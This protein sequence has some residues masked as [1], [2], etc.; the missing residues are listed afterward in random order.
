MGAQQGHRSLHSC[1]YAILANGT[2][3]HL[4]LSCLC[5]RLAIGDYT[6]SLIVGYF[7]SQQSCASASIQ[8]AL[9]ELNSIHGR[10]GT[11]NVVIRHA[12]QMSPRTGTSIHSRA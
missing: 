3:E 12:P 10:S 9:S 11:W 8:A 7:G 6:P 1:W 2:P 4:Q 5:N